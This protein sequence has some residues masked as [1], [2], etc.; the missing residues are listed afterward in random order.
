MRH[1]LVDEDVPRSTA[2]VL[3]AARCV[4]QDVRDVGLRGHSDA[5]VFAYAQAN[6]AILVSCDKGLAS[7]LRF[8]LGSHAGIVVIRIPDEKTPTE[9][10]AE[11]L[12]TLK[13][14]EAESFL[15]PRRQCTSWQA[16]WATHLPTS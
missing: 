16:N 11:L 6:A 7:L 14:L 4:A 13:Q 1:F 5:E 9:L 8:P 15:L 3:A 2:K 10:N 12:R